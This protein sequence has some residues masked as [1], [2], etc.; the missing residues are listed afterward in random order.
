MPRRG[1]SGRARQRVRCSTDAWESWAVR[2]EGCKS[3]SHH[4]RHQLCAG[5][6]GKSAR[7]GS[8][9]IR[10]ISGSISTTPCMTFPASVNKQNKGRHIPSPAWVHHLLVCGTPSGARGSVAARWPI[11]T[12][13]GKSHVRMVH[14]KVNLSVTS[15]AR[16][17]LERKTPV[18]LVLFWREACLIGPH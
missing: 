8:S 3:L 14:V 1:R 13:R 15:H 12:N 7:K 18:E 17:H 10:A 5:D 2:G 6:R 16:P 4:A 11:R 9:N